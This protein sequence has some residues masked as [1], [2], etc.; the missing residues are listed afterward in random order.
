MKVRG[1]YDQSLNRYT[2]VERSSSNNNTLNPCALKTVPTV[3]KCI[4]T[5]TE[6]SRRLKD[7]VSLNSVDDLASAACGISHPA[8][9]R[10]LKVFCCAARPAAQCAPNQFKDTI[11]NVSLLPGQMAPLSDWQLVNE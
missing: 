3:T 4:N 1:N 8:N 10:D 2:E 11:D 5:Q 9:R 6:I 7:G